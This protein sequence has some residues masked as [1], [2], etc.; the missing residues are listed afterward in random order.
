MTDEL[1][2]LMAVMDAA[3]DPLYREAWTR[4]QVEDALLTG[5]CRYFLANCSN[6]FKV[7]VINN[8]NNE[9]ACAFY[10]SREIVNE[11]ELLLFAVSPAFRGKGIGFQL[12]DHLAETARSNGS[13]RIF[14]EM[15]QGNPAE[16][17]YRRFGFAPVGVRPNYYRF[18]DG[19]RVDAITF[20]MTI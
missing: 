13:D 4:R 15:R 2:R 16:N 6:S 14:L 20:A 1:D 11:T 19:T 9:T 7:K 10:L 5:H 12:L 18:L 17:L 3:F 8:S